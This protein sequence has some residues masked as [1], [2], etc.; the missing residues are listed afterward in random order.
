MQDGQ[1]LYIK[2][3]N[4]FTD[5]SVIVNGSLI[6]ENGKIKELMMEGQQPKGLSDKMQTIDAQHA[7]VIPGFIDGHIHGA[8]GADVMDATEDALD[9]IAGVLPE[10]GTTSFLATT[11]T[12]SPANIDRAVENV[13]NYTNKPGQAEIIGIHLE[14]PF[15]EKGKKGAQPS[16]YIMN[17]SISQFQ[18]WQKLS[19]NKIKTITLAPEHDPDGSFISY[20]MKTGVNVSAG[21]TLANFS[22]MKLAISYGVRQVTHLCNA[23]TGIHHRDIGVVGAAFQLDDLRAELIADGIHVSLEMLQLI[24]DNMGSERLLLITDAMRAKCLPPGN[25]ELGGQPVLVTEDRAVLDDG[26]LAGSILKMAQAARNMLNLR[27]VT[28]KEVIEMTAINPAKQLQVY[29]DKGSITVGK[30]AD[31][32]LVDDDL[33]IEMTVCRGGIAYRREN[34]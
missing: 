32:L 24:Y 13:A 5:K 19:G 2:H 16:A 22:E 30:D 10:E 11:I 29:D 4:I 26:T 20:L 21:H 27:D 14:G 34:K 18:K 7:N 33:S 9:R 31:I 6:I 28:I 1:S 15:I 12:Q 17:P 3:A 25:Y 8:N 23:M